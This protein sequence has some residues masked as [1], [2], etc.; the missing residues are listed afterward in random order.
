MASGNAQAKLT[1]ARTIRL[2]DWLEPYG[3]LAMRGRISGEEYFWFVRG[4]RKQHVAM[5][6]ACVVM[7]MWEAQCAKPLKTAKQK[8]LRKHP[9]AFCKRHQMGFAVFFSVLGHPAGTGSTP[10]KA[11]AN[12]VLRGYDKR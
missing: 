1:K 3:K 11:W 5:M 6:P 8:I 2:G 12:A 10:A 9:S 7:P 4:K